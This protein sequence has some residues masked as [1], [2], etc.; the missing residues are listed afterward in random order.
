MNIMMSGWR[1]VDR[2][3]SIP[4]ISH[5]YLPLVYD[6]ITFSQFRLIADLGLHWIGLAAPQYPGLAYPEVQPSNLN[7]LARLCLTKSV[8]FALGISS[9]S[10]WLVQACSLPPSAYTHLII[11]PAFSIHTHSIS[12][13]C[14]QTMSGAEVIA[15]VACVAA[16]RPSTV[17]VGRNANTITS[18][19]RLPRWTPAVPRHQKEMGQAPTA[20]IYRPR[21]IADPQQGGHPHALERTRRPPRRPLRRRRLDRPRADERHRH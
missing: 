4:S 17:P 16:G 19:L 6:P 15:V 1:S 14:H 3:D 11:Y 8:P 7:R 9:F 2:I 20:G 21:A 12:T 13:C 18:R 10:S 5:L